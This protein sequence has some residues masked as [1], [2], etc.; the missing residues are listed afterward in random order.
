M[1]VIL[2]I[3]LD[4]INYFNC[5]EQNKYVHVLKFGFQNAQ[6]IFL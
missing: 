1:S 5:G 4:M 3:K 2:S 6:K